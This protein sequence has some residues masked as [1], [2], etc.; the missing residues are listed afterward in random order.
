MRTEHLCLG[1]AIALAFAGIP[2]LAAAQSSSTSTALAGIDTTEAPRVTQAVNNQVVAPLQ[3]SHL[4]ALDTLQPVAAVPSG[5]PMNHMHLMLRRSALRQAALDSLITAQHDPQSA[6]FHRWVTPD[7]FG[8]KF[9]VSDADIAAVTAWLRSNGLTVNGVYP[10]R[11][12][13][14]F[15]G[16]AAQVERAFH[17]QINRYTLDGATHV[18]NASDVSVP[19]ALKDV[20]VGVAGLNDFHP[21]PQHVPMKVG[22]FDSATHRF[23]IQPPAGTATAAAQPLAIGFT[24]GARGLVPY[25]MAKMYGVDKLRDSGLTGKGITIAVVEDGSMVPG[26]WKNFV[27]QFSLGGYGGTF[28]QFQPQAPG[29]TNCVDPTVAYPGEDDGETLLDAEW[30]TAIAPGAT[31]W[32]ASCDDSNSDNFFGGVFTAA[33][34][35]INGAKRPNVISASY[36]YGESFTDA[37][38]K[39]AIDL[40]WAQADAEGI[41]VFVSSG[42]SGSNPSFNGGIINSVGIDANSFGTS[43]N[44]TVVGGTDTADVLDGTTKKY[45]SADFNT[46]YGSALSY[47]PEIPWNESCG[48]EV[49]AASLG[50]PSALAFCKEYLKLDPYGYYL[51]S[52]AGSGGPSSIDRKPAWQRLVHGA[53][54]DQSRD[55]PDVSLFGGSY[56]GATWVIVCTADYPC[57]PDFAGLVALSGGTSL[58]S[59]M[60]AGIQALIDQGLAKQGL[61]PNQGNAAPTLYALAMDEYGGASGAVPASLATCSSD[62]G[63]KGT[64][65]CVFHNITRGSIATQCVQQ[66]PDIATPDCY[67]YG[68]LPN[69]FY[70][71]LQVGLTSTKPGKYNANTEA[72]AAR[73][74]W[75]FATG[76]GSVNA[77][78]LLNAW[79]VFVGVK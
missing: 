43:P 70:G 35:L 42:D 19:A 67:Y 59:P 41:S 32:V 3:K 28:K 27:K 78:N 53:A 36:G 31:V 8:R 75:S 18:A 55:V 57:Q 17:T 72:Y 65:K 22:R 7:Q 34:N 40:M 48:N 71:P 5:T 73:P 15:S 51:T 29:F 68:A 44:D 9:G 60:F 23:K 56:G 47:V 38:S 61:T 77:K 50:F 6:R 49:A 1:M 16:D 74:G 2:T 63:A 13:I 64:G 62:N 46:E 58:S 33:T 10:N 54:K 25:D 14:D 20:V 37:A 76:L 11:M 39:A 4:A 66:L 45:F 12:Q 30:A 26:D 69:S 79:E 52:E 24:N 21:Q